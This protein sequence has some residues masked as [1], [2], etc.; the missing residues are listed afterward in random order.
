MLCLKLSLWLALARYFERTDDLFAS[1][2]PMLSYEKQALHPKSTPWSL[3]WDGVNQQDFIQVVLPLS[4]LWNQLM[5][6][7]A[8]PHQPHPKLDKEGPSFFWDSQALRT[9]LLPADVECLLEWWAVVIFDSSLGCRFSFLS[10][11]Q[12]LGRTGGGWWLT[13][14][15]DYF[16][17]RSTFLFS[18]LPMET[19]KWT[20]S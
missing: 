14:I 6:V 11:P 1:W 5:D 7:L 2:G 13:Y 16:V 12:N 15:C 8:T 3:L 4:Y 18:L 9:C 20:Q 10:F 17:G 19:R